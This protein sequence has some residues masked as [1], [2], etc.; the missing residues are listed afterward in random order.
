MPPAAVLE[1]MPVESRRESRKRET[2]A[3]LLAAGRRLFGDEGLYDSR[4]E[5]LTTVAGIAKGTIYGYFEDKQALVHAVVAA[6]LAEL[7]AH[8]HARSAAAESVVK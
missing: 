3:R 5:D 1:V 2:R 7:L 8:V 4:I 6:A